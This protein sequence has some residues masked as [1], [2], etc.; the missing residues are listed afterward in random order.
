MR[1]QQKFS[2]FIAFFFNFSIVIYK[3][4][5][6]LYAILQSFFFFK[7]NLSNL[8]SPIIAYVTFKKITSTC[9][10]IIWDFTLRTSIRRGQSG[11][12]CRSMEFKCPMTGWLARSTCSQLE[13]DHSHQNP[14]YYSIIWILLWSFCVF[15][16]I[17]LFFPIQISPTRFSVEAKF[18]C[19]VCISKKIYL[20]LSKLLFST[21]L[22]V[23]D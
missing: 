18:L 14:K 5:I 13:R 9:I 6:I 21:I 2:E 20:H 10:R 19:H 23:L 15:I 4:Q 3:I 16:V 7:K 17:L 22:W 1:N 11:L 12:I 8:Y